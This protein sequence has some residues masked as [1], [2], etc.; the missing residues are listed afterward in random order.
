M[1]NGNKTSVS[2]IL[3]KSVYTSP[4]MMIQIYS[5]GGIRCIIHTNKSM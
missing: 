1:L 4:E 5:K 3:V 2:V